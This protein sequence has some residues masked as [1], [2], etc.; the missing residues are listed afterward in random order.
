MKLQ[1]TFPVASV[2]RL[3]V[4]LERF[5]RTLT[6]KPIALASPGIMK[7]VLPDDLQPGDW[8]ISALSLDDDVTARLPIAMYIE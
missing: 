2:D 3:R 4:I 7:I 6:L 8:Q 1:G 5:G